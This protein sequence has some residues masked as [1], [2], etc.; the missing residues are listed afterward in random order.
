MNK[1]SLLHIGSLAQAT[2]ERRR[3][4]N[5]V[6]INRADFEKSYEYFNDLKVSVA[7]NELLQLIN[8]L[9]QKN[10]E[11]QCKGCKN[12]YLN[13]NILIQPF[14]HSKLIYPNYQYCKTIGI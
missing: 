10:F 8:K 11:G 2:Y 4:Y 12:A 7:T 9:I 14:Y 5:I 6:V 3:I 1:M 13:N